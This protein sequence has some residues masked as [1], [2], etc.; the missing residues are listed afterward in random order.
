M[1]GQ[2][3]R[4]YAAA[5]IGLPGR[6]G[7]GVVPVGTRLVFSCSAGKLQIGLLRNLMYAAFLSVRSFFFWAGTPQ[8]VRRTAFVG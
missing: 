1:S 5:I 7:S 6:S 4:L 3:L 2:L 8:R